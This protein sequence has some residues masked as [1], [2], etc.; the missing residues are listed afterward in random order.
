MN[1]RYVT[2]QEKKRILMLHSEGMSYNVIAREVNRS[3]KVIEETVRNFKSE[4]PL[5]F[6]FPAYMK[7]KWPING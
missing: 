5:A 2:E 6:N 7:N 3:T 4:T 1:K